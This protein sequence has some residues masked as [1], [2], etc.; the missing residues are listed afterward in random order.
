MRIA[1][2]TVTIIIPSSQ[3]LKDKRRIIKSIKDRLRVKYN[4]AIAEVDG[5]DLWQRST[6]AIVS[7]SNDEAFLNSV[8]STIRGEIENLVPGHIAE[9]HLEIL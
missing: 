8:F 9:E 2:Y 5:Q 4:I 6:L 1:A 7:V 3:S